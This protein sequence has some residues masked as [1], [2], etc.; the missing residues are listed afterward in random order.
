MSRTIRKIAVAAGIL[1]LLLLILPFVIPVNSCR[2]LIESLASAALGRSVRIGDLS[3]SILRGSLSAENLSIADDPRFSTSPFLRCTGLL[4]SLLAETMGILS[5]SAAA[6]SPQ[7]Q[8]QSPLEITQI[9]LF[10][11]KKWNSMQVSVLGLML[12]MTRRETLMVAL[13]AGLRLDDDLGQGCLKEKTCNVVEG[14]KYNGMSLIY[15]E[16]E[17]LEKIRIEARIRHVSKEERSG[18]LVSRFQGDT[19][20]L[21]ES[22]SDSV[23]NQVLGPI[24]AMWVGK[25]KRFP[26]W[27]PRSAGPHPLFHRRG[28]QYKKHGLI[29]YVDLHEPDPQ[30]DD[31]IE[32]LTLEFVPPKT[33]SR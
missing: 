27:D 21:F 11:V 1:I 12:G 13:K 8:A 33:L 30:S 9:D 24:D 15:G 5:T 19:R 7:N 26:D 32:K 2:P 17:I 22:Y 6:R 4:A 20:R 25:M 16:D 31:D 3:L 14:D 18:R 10:S 29:L 28:Y 23:R